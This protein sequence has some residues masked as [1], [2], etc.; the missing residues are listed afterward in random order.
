M[1]AFLLATRQGGRAL[2]RDDIGVI[3]VGAKADIVCFN[4]SSPNMLGWTNAV[5]AVMMHANIGDIEHVL[6]GGQWRKRD[7][8]LVSKTKRW[9]EIKREFVECARRIQSEARE[10]AKVPERFMGMGEMGDVEVLGVRDSD[11]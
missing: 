5:A 8:K 2:H 9:D 4:T 10:P 7:G 3:K 1:D 11:E 6:V